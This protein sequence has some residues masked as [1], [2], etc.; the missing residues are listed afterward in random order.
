CLSGLGD[1]LATCSSRLSR[2]Y[3]V[4]YKLAV[5]QKLADILANLEGTAEGVN[6]TKVVME[7]A[8]LKRISV[9]ITY[10]VHRLLQ[11]EIT[12]QAAVE[13]LMLR[14]TKPE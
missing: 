5:G 12:P 13:A 11:G 14:D 6:T 2:N 8:K 3:Q 1:L 7:R 10:Q 9:P 4:G